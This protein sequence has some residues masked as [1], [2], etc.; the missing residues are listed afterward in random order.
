LGRVRIVL[1]VDDKVDPQAVREVVLARLRDHDDVLAEPPPEVYFTDV[2]N[3][4]LEMTAFGYLASA[5]YAFRVKSELLF[6]IVPDLTAKGIA[7][8]SPATVVNVGLSGS[9][10]EPDA[11]GRAP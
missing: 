2:H 11:R 4:A 9:T 7:L 10:N 3:G 6:G 8:A 1:R 5:R